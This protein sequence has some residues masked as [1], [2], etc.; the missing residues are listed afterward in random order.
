M[1]LIWW[2]AI[3][4]MVGLLLTIHGFRV[5]TVAAKKAAA[6]ANRAAELVAVVR[7]DLILS[8]QAL[9]TQLASLQQVGDDTHSL[10]N[11]AMGHQLRMLANKARQVANITNDPLDLLEAS[12]ADEALASHMRKQARVDKAVQTRLDALPVKPGD[13]TLPQ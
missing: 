12:A 2:V 7:S 13:E 3:S 4:S 8:N 6:T 10:V 1:L 5:Q 9:K 11:S